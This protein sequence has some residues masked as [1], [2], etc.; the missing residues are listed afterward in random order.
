M[1]F[2][3]DLWGYGMIFFTDPA[4]R[5]KCTLRLDFGWLKD[6]RDIDCLL[7]LAVS[8][9][10]VEKSR[11]MGREMLCWELLGADHGMVGNQLPIT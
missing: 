8:S 10:Q 2:A 9:V 7:L 4:P 5:G 6:I 1:G 3:V 11:Y